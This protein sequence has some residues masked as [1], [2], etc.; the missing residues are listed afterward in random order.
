VATDTVFERTE[1][2]KGIIELAT[3]E[4]ARIREEV[5]KSIARIEQLKTEFSVPY[6]ILRD[7]GAEAEPLTGTAAF[8]AHMSIAVEERDERIAELE[9]ELAAARN[10]VQASTLLQESN[11]GLRIEL[12][13]ARSTIT[14]RGNEIEKATTLAEELRQQISQLQSAR[15]EEKEGGPKPQGESQP[16]RQAESRDAEPRSSNR[17]GTEPAV[18]EAQAREFVQSL[19]TTFSGATVARHFGISSTTAGRLLR[20]LG[21]R[22]TIKRPD[23]SP[24]K[25]PHAKWVFVKPNGGGPRRRPRSEPSPSRGG[26]APAPV[27]G[28]GRPNGPAETPGKLKRQQR[29]APRVRHKPVKGVRV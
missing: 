10:G 14:Q 17:K 3:D 1:F 7:M 28:T 25:G 24:A 22:G 21:E 5:A 27:P 4:A 26:G 19:D 15:K 12:Q 13:T 29:K 6:R 9:T 16:E 23:D 20:K 2:E 18:T 11:N 8:N